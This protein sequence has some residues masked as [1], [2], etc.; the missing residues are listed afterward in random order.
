MSMTTSKQFESHCW[1]VL[2]VAGTGDHVSTT[3]PCSSQNSER[4]NRAGRWHACNAAAFPACALSPLSIGFQVALRLFQT[5]GAALPLP[6][7]MQLVR[8]VEVHRRPVVSGEHTSQ[9]HPQPGMC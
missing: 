2:F 3:A 6:V 1:F 9:P 4:M 8:W 5:A 7:H